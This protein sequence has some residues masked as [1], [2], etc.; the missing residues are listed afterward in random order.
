VDCH[1]IW[2]SWSEETSSV[3]EALLAASSVFRAGRL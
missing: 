2:I 3:I 1:I